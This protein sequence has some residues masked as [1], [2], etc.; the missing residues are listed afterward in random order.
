MGEHTDTPTLNVVNAALLLIATV[1]AVLTVQDFLDT[2]LG[3]GLS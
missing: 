1:T 2:L 3:G